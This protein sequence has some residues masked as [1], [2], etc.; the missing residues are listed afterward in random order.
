M[1]RPALA[2]S[3]IVLAGLSAMLGGCGNKGPLI[4]PP[5]RSLPVAPYGRT[6]RPSAE[7]LLKPPS[8]TRPERSVEPAN[9]G[10][11]RQP[12]PFDLPPEG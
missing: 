5:G 8:Q 4:P 1:N 6:S 3:A 2:V 7:E 11:E 12:D 9:P 10:D